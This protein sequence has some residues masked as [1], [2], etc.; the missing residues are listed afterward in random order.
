MFDALAPRYDLLNSVLSAGLDRRWRRLAAAAC[1]VGPGSRVLDLACGSGR[2]S[3]ELKA[4]V[5]PGTVVG[6]DFSASMLEVARR[7]AQGPRWVRADAHRL[8][9]SDASF[10]AVSVAFGLRNFAH[11][12]Q[13]LEEMLRVLRPGGRAVVLEF[14]RPDPGLVGSVYR[15]YL[16]HGLP[17]IGGLLSGQGSAY[18]YLS[19]S[20]DSYRSSQEL[21]G[22]ARSAG[23]S[24][25][26]IRL[27]NLGT[28]GLLRGARA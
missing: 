7:S 9:F 25:I 10:D 14:V 3:A 4:R 19:D 18:R 20:V 27:L 13:A 28:V 16:R 17:R 6:L 23:W 2:L 11:P 8:P 21:M 24:G 5:G 22:L 15:G 26:E 1:A 12:T